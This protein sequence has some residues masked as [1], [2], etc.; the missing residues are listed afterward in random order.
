M[1]R[2]VSSSAAFETITRA[3]NHA[4]WITL[5]HG[6]SQ[7][8]RLF[9]RQVEVFQDS[10]HL[11][12]I[13]LPGHGRSSDV[14]GPYGLQDYA[15]SIEGVLGD[16]GA[17]AC[18][19]WGTHIGAGA[20]L[21]LASRRPGL[22][23]SLVL[24]APVFPGRPLPAVNDLLP[25]ISA[26]A[27]EQG[28]DAA[29]EAWWQ[30]GAWFDVMRRHPKSCRAAEQRRIIDGFQGQPWL[31]AGFVSQ[32]PKA[33]DASLTGLKAPTM[34]INGEHDLPDFVAIAGQLETLMPYAERS[35][36]KGAGGF[37]LW[38]F[39]DETNQ[40]VMDFLSRHQRPR[41]TSSHR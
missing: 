18:H 4:P 24:E 6:L 9:D 7:D 27:K 2:R 22:F 8:H 37:P 3:A 35:V 13:D 34:I 23:R 40:I 26:I 14:P 1:A 38:E 10:Y 30:E 5:V 21:L 25:R 33:I 15:R 12:L 17:L 28:M 20:G 29:R 36:V 39:P 41:D 16:V 11:L 32:R 31:D 19:F